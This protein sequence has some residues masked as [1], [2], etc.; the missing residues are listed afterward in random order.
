MNANKFGKPPRSAKCSRHLQIFSQASSEFAISAEG[1]CDGDGACGGCLMEVK[2]E[3]MLL[4]AEYARLVSDATL[5]MEQ[6]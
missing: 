4:I 1:G 3:L 5:D 6:T 2:K